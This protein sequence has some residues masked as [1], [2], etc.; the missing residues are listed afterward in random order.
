MIQTDGSI[1]VS[2]KTG[3]RIFVAGTVCSNVLYMFGENAMLHET[4]A[5]ELIN[6]T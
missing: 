2:G 6:Q 3:Y 4:T 5:D 1:S